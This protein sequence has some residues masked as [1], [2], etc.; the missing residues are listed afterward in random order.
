MGTPG[1][2]IFRQA[3]T[4]AKATGTQGSLDS[5]NSDDPYDYDTLAGSSG[6]TSRWCF[7]FQMGDGPP[8]SEF[9]KDDPLDEALDLGAIFLLDLVT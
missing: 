3:H 1:Y 5:L 7:F 9:K 6:P 4:E 8:I 2:P